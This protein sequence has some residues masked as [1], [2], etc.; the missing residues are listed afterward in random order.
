P[1]LEALARGAVL[2][3]SDGS[4]VGEVVDDAALRVDP[5]DTPAIASALSRA[6]EDDDL[7]TDMSARGRDRAREFTWDRCAEAHARIYDAARDV[8][9][10]RS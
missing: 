2:V 4:G 9:A 7:R 1:A 5:R 6:L 10:R 8:D 3:C